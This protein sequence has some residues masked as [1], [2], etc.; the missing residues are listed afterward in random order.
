MAIQPHFSMLDFCIS[1]YYFWSYL[2]GFVMGSAKIF[3]TEIKTW[4]NPSVTKIRKRF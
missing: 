1:G 2:A 4:I 3:P